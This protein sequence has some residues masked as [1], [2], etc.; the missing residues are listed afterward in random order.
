MGII[1]GGLLAVLFLINLIHVIFGNRNTWLIC[2]V[3]ML[4]LSN[5]ALMVTSII[6]FIMWDLNAVTRTQIHVQGVSWA[7]SDG[8]FSIAHFLLAMKYQSIT[9]KIPSKLDGKPQP[10][11]TKGDVFMYWFLLT[12]NIVFPILET[13]SIIPYN[14]HV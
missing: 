3:A 14:I 10:P 12:M 9:R 11:I 13:V 2:V 8:F 6:D 7:I 4:M 1:A 5:I